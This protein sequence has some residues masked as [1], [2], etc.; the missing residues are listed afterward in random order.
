MSHTPGPWHRQGPIYE[1]ECGIAGGVPVDVVVPSDEEGEPAVSVLDDLSVADADLIAAAPD[2]LVALKDAREKL[3]AA[4]CLLEACG[5]EFVRDFSAS[6]S[7]N[8]DGS[9]E[10]DVCGLA[11]DCANAADRSDAAIAKAEGSA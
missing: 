8:Y 6:P 2:L 11:V 4:S 7:I 10:T 3:K 5:D 9:G 1:D